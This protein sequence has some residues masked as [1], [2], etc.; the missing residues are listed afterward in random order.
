MSPAAGVTMA[1]VECGHWTLGS[2]RQFLEVGSRAALAADSSLTRDSCG[3]DPGWL[4]SCGAKHCYHCS[5]C[6]RCHPGIYYP[7]VFLTR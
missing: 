6:P 7:L 5:H 1:S 4:W 2:V 3:E